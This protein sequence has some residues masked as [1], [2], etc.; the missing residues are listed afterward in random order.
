MPI[1][2]CIWCLGLVVT[3]LSILVLPAVGQTSS[4]VRDFRIAG[5]ASYIETP[6][7]DVICGEDYDRYH[8]SRSGQVCAGGRYSSYHEGRAGEVA[9][10]G[11][12]SGSHQSR[13]ALAD[14][15]DSRATTNEW[16]AT[17]P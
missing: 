9:C 13:T 6:D 2:K 3:L 11:L 7:G 10:G 1:M 8:E 12:C 15:L 5:Y 17:K 16:C 4:S 14:A